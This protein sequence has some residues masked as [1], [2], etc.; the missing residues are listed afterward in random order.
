MLMSK[1]YL[2]V[3][4]LNIERV[5]KAFAKGAQAVIIDLEDAVSD[6]VKQQC[7][8]NL[9]TYLTSTTAQAVWVRI[10]AVD[11]EWF[12]QDIELVRKLDN[13]CGIV[14]PKVE[15]A[16]DIAQLYHHISDK[17]ILALIETPKGM[18]NIAKIA[19]AQGLTALSYGF[20]DICQQLSVKAD[21]EA[22]QMLANQIRYQLLL[23]SQLN[24]LTAPIDCVYPPFNDHDGLAKRV[25]WWR[26]L[27]FSGML[28]I[29][30]NQ[31]AIVNDM[32]KPTEA[33]LVF[34]K[35][36]V[37]Y[38]QKTQLA[39]F[40]ID[41]EMVDTPVIKQAIALLNSES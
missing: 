21:S 1:S 2:F 30:P 22:G 27:G 3:P 26:D 12:A 11:S 28:C 10:N 29:H 6:T 31:V 19:T 32:A 9:K 39:A 34:A 25:A 5:P 14:L 7:Q 38:Y 16:D 36:V 40:A 33:Q 23:H 24:G 18:A 13:I 41:G 15:T 35:K 17:P 8:T 37:D 20:L 4:A